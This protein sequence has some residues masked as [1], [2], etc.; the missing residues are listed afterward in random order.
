MNVKISKFAAVLLLFCL[1]VFFLSEPALAKPKHARPAK[2]APL[3]VGFYAKTCPIAEKI[4]RIAV[5]EAVLLNPGI[6]AGLIRMH[7]HDCFVR[8]RTYAI[9]ALLCQL[10]V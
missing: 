2:V 8:V 9:Q 10:L 5:N 7:F 3:K 1:V 6:A 4:V